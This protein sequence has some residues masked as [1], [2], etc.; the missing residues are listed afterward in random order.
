MG[1]N[2]ELSSAAIALLISLEAAHPK[3]YVDAYGDMNIGVGHFM[4]QKKA[5]PHLLQVVG[6][7]RAS[8]LKNLKLSDS[9]INDLLLLDCGVKCKNLAAD[10]GHLNLLTNEID[11]LILFTFNIG[12]TG[13]RNSEVRKRLLNNRPKL[14][15]ADQFKN[16]GRVNNKIERG[17]LKR[18][19]VEAAVFLKDF[20]AVPKDY[21]KKFNVNIKEAE[22]IF[23]TYLEAL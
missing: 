9:E 13:F 23:A 6:E 22:L 20:N 18:R 2:V 7:S 3:I 11:A 17:L 4:P 14:E 5:T 8:D 21:Y 19:L 12:T 15:I 10:I 16:W 1:V